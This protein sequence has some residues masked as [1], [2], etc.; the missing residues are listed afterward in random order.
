MKPRCRFHVFVWSRGRIMKPASS[1][2][3]F[4]FS[5]PV[6]VSTGYSSA[7]A[8]SKPRTLEK[9]RT[10]HGRR[11]MKPMQTGRMATI[12]ATLTALVMFTTYSAA[13]AK[14]DITG[15][16]QFYVQTEAGTGT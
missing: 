1:F 15:K 8:R 10:D 6:F 4:V 7:N 16:W 2:R 5:W 11:A 13:Q 14:V 9:S 3:V 12:A